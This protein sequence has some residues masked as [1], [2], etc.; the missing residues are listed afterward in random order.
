[1]KRILITGGSGF[2]GKNLALHLKKDKKFKI[3]LSSRNIENLRKASA[4]TD[5]EFYPMDINSIDSII[6]T[7]NNV[8]PDI[9]IHSAATKFVDLSEKYPEEC[10]QTN[11]LGS[12]NLLR[13]SKMFKVKGVIAIS[14]DKAANPDFNVYSQSKN[15]MEKYFINNSKNSKVKIATV[16]FG[17]LCWST[18]SVFN[19][20]EEMSIKN[21]MVLSTGPEMRRF[22]IHVDQACNLIIKVMK[23]LD[24]CNGYIIT[25]YM[26]SAKISNILNIW[27]EIYNVKWKK[28]K[29][30]FGDKLDEYLFSPNEI[31][32]ANIFTL[33][34]KK[35]IK[36][37]YS[38][39]NL[40]YFKD[41]ITSK[42]SLKLSSEEI[43]KLI[44][45]KPRIL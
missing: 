26:K 38:K 1:M 27:S 39:Q 2:L 37:D 28:I 12:I 11:I 15:M 19:L 30:R 31:K 23:N 43:K 29:P 21:K 6:D 14:T 10:I 9:V 20:W 42:N 35:L 36:I 25:E 41:V 8:M 16:R 45:S 34:K 22:F 18:G 40:N 13:V 17:N 24:K 5:C 44:L 32:S 4:V 33:N 3:I 7:F